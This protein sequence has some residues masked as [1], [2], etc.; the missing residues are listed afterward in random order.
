MVWY[1]MSANQPGYR[2][3]DWRVTA[4]DAYTNLVASVLSEDVQRRLISY[5]VPIAN[6]VDVVPIGNTK[7]SL[8]RLYRALSSTG[9]IQGS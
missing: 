8:V 4:D 6:S 9:I 1:A 3:R 5:N 2:R 7:K